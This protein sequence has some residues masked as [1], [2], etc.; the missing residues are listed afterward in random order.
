VWFFKGLPSRIGQ[1]LDMSLASWEDPVLRGVR[2]PRKHHR[3]VAK[4]PGIK[5]KTSSAVDKVRKL[6]EEPARRAEGRMGARPSDCCATWTWTPLAR[7]LRA[8]MLGETS[9]PEAQERSSAPQGHRGVPQSGN[10]PDWMILEVVPVSRRSCARWCL[11]G[12]RFATSDLNDLVSA[13]DNRNNRLK[14]LMI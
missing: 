14:R 6:Q 11:D 7:D 1:L 3:A 13:G 9:V 4:V 10:Q 12:G 8:Q 2:G 5:K